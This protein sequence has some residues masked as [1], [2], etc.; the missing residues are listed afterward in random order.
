[1]V[2]KVRQLTISAEQVEALG[3]HLD[4]PTKDGHVN[5]TKLH[6]ILRSKAIDPKEGY[7]LQFN[8]NGDWIVYQVT[9][10]DRPVYEIEELEQ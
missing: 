5:N 6:K 2:H 9:V 3:L 7:A 4:V 10:T 1:M 8:N